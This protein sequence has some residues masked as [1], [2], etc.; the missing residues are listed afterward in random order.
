MKHIYLKCAFL[1]AVLAVVEAAWF[2]HKGLRDRFLLILFLPVAAFL[3]SSLVAKV[4]SR[5]VHALTVPVWLLALVIWAGASCLAIVGLS[6][7]ITGGQKVTD[8]KQYEEIVNTFWDQDMVS[9]FPRSIP[10]DAKN[11]RFEFQ[12]PFLQGGTYVILAYT[13]EPEQIE[14]LYELHMPEVRESVAGHEGGSP[15]RFMSED[16]H[17][18]SADYEVL[19]FDQPYKTGNHSRRRGITI[20]KKLSK[21]IFWLEAM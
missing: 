21:V 18:A 7:E 13:T 17:P 6:I 5:E 11:V 19:I 16:I 14:T 4:S 12:P 20:N 2:Y 9:H 8:I 10:I 15:L 1:F 3:Y